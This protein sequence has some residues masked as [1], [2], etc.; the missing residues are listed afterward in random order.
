MGVDHGGRRGL[1]GG[2]SLP[3]FGVGDANAHCPVRFCHICTKR[4]VLG[5]SK[6]F[7]PGLYPG[8]PDPAGGAHDAPQTP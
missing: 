7:R 8:A 1:D 4:S 3:E 6:L 5:P 2:T